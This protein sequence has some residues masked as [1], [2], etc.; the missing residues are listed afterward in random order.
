M[1]I[2][3]THTYVTSSYMHV[4]DWCSY[5]LRL[6]CPYFNNL[7][8][9]LFSVV[10]FVLKATEDIFK[11]GI[12]VLMILHSF[13]REITKRYDNILRP[14]LRAEGEEII[15][16]NNVE[17]KRLILVTNLS[18]EEGMDQPLYVS[19]GNLQP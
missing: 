19:L 10:E 4:T 3:S 6:I 13:S 7:K 14:Q 15:S 9:I 17:K 8:F 18:E 5:K 2:Y 1:L 12:Y 16:E 11:A